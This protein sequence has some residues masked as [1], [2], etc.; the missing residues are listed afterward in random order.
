MKRLL[1]MMLMLLLGV[2][3]S[4]GQ[5]DLSEVYVTTQDYAVLRAGPGTIWGR[6]AVLPYGQIYRATGRTIDGDWIQVAYEGSID[7]GARTDF[8]LDGVTYGWVGYWLLTWT[9]DILQLP[10]DGIQ[11]VPTARAAGPTIVLSPGEYMYVGGV[12]L[13]TQVDTPISSPVRVEVTGRL[14]SAEAGYFWIQFK[15]GGKYYWTGS[16]AVGV[17]GGYIDTPDASYL[18]AYGYL[19]TRV[20]V[21]IGRAS[22]VLSD[23]GGRWSALDAGQATTCNTIPEDFALRS[24]SFPSGTLAGE[25]VFAPIAEAMRN[26]EVS[27]NAALAKFRAICAAPN[28]LVDPAQISAGIADVENAERN[29]VIAGT[30]LDPLQRRDPLLQN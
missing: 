8:T 11:N 24:N 6:L 4:Q 18:Y 17:P 2:T 19:L 7:A 15:L 16:W 1:I 9:G 12:D 13:S 10:I 21:E 26:A 3:I 20:R 22:E 29:L 25:P 14:G 30:L 23:V 5:R 27:I 28:Q